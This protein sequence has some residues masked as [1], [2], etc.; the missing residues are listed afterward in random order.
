[1]GYYNGKCVSITA[2]NTLAS[3][4]MIS[5]KPTSKDQ[6]ASLWTSPAPIHSRNFIAGPITTAP[7]EVSQR[8]ASSSMGSYSNS[9]SILRDAHCSLE[10]SDHADPSA[11]NNVHPP[12]VK[13]SDPSLPQGLSW[14]PAA[15]FVERDYHVLNFK[16]PATGTNIA[17]PPAANQG[18]SNPNDEFAAQMSTLHKVLGPVPPVS[19]QDPLKTTR[20][21]ANQ[22]ASTPVQ[23]DS[24]VAPGSSDS[25][26]MNGDQFPQPITS[27]SQLSGPSKSIAEDGVQSLQ[28]VSSNPP[29]PTPG[30]SS[31]SVENGVQSRQPAGSD[32]GPPKPGSDN[33]PPPNTGTFP[34]TTRLG[35]QTGSKPAVI[36][37]GSE[38]NRDPN[39]FGLAANF[40]GD[41]VSVANPKDGSGTKTS[42][43]DAANP[44]VIVAGNTLTISDP[45]SVSIAGTVLTP[46]GA[47]ATIAGTPVSLASGGDL[48]I[49]ATAATQQSAIITA[50]DQISTA[51]SA[52]FAV[53]DTTVAA[54]GSAVLLAGTAVSLGTSGVL[55]VGNST[56]KLTGSPSP[57]V[58][59]VGGLTLTAN[60]TAFSLGG[61]ILSAGGPAVLVSGTPIHLGPSGAPVIGSTTSLLPDQLHSPV[62]T[63]GGQSLI[64]N[65]TG[66]AVAGT[67]VAPGQPGLTT[68]G[69]PISL[70]PSG[71]PIVGTS[72]IPL[73]NLPLL[74]FTTDGQTPTLEGGG[75]VA[76]DGAALTDGKPGTSIS[77]KSMG[78]H[79]NNFITGTS[80]V[81]SPT[82]NASISTT[83]DASSLDPTS[84][85]PPPVP[86]TP[87]TGEPK[88][89][90][91]SNNAR[92][93]TVIWRVFYVVASVLCS[94]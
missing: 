12:E 53:A 14:D 56:T 28:P 20:P 58:V 5:A 49:G 75:L 11:G 81:P 13:P 39:N 87:S 88:A 50:G 45:S 70:N 46:G 47:Q 32:G 31:A 66:L 26:T 42:S 79:S 7:L 36:F 52:G 90:A 48:V 33:S 68:S 27:D 84:T 21:V 83:P 89:A 73:G 30:P 3:P 62:F 72:T 40:N 38:I 63:L 51:H 76:F 34:T 74:V 85:N 17:N 71:S 57:S 35:P 78:V 54:G 61:T 55:V 41:A 29:V 18:P 69:R 43:T 44:R 77:G 91:T 8:K 67:S 93:P 6:R 64:A 65:P 15:N 86:H 2:C 22:P 4:S 60:P 9:T 19:P 23:P 1:M 37:L 80:A 25:H 92:A 24:V 10:S 94:T 59:T 16:K 82:I